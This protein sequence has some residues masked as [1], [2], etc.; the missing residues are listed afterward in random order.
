MKKEAA[1]IFGIH[2]VSE[3]LQ[4]GR[5]IDKLILRQG[6]LNDRLKEVKQLARA[7]NI[8]VQ[9]VPDIRLDRLSKGEPHQ[10]VVAI[11]AAIS[12]QSLEKLL[13]A[14]HEAKYQPLLVMLDGVTDVRNFGAI[15]RSC[16]VM[17]ADALVV[18]AKRSAAANGDALRA[19]AGALNHLALCRET[20]L[21]DTVMLLQAYDIRC[22]AMD[23]KIDRSI[24]D[25]ELQGSLCLI[26]GSEEKGITPSV[27]KRVDEKGSI[28]QQGQTSSL[29]VSV[30]VGMALLEATR[31][32]APGLA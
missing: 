10:G 27:L 25:M 15:A 14:W 21:I 13:L 29:N 20:N 19:S 6:G 31:Q 24:F 32:R 28:P 4:A 12:F 11:A 18:P 7:Q 17:G 26:F 5:S 3:A 2:A 8:P 23:E 16:E 22:I 30:S 9:T 1:P